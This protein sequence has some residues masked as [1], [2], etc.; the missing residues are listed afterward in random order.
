[1]F[2]SKVERL[3]YKIGKP[4][5]DSSETDVVFVGLGILI[6][7]YIFKWKAPIILGACAGALTTT[8]AIGAICEK[9]KVIHLY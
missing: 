4:A 2:I 7:K 1:M 6:G 9:A 5:R 8:A 3:A